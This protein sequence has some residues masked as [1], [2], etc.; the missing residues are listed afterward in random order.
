MAQPLDFTKFPAGEIL[1]PTLGE[2]V[3]VKGFRRDAPTKIDFAAVECV[4]RNVC[5][6]S[7]TKCA[8]CALNRFVCPECCAMYETVWRAVENPARG[9]W[10]RDAPKRKTK[11]EKDAAMK[12][13]PLQTDVERLESETA[14]GDDLSAE[15]RREAWENKIR[16]LAAAEDECEQMERLA[17]EIAKSLKKRREKLAAKRREHT[18]NGSREYDE[19]DE[20]PLLTLAE[21]I[22]AQEAAALETGANV[23][24]T[25]EAMNRAA[26]Q[27]FQKIDLS[28]WEDAPVAALENAL[29]PVI[30]AA[31]SER[32][33]TLGELS[34]WLD[35]SNRAKIGLAPKKIEAIQEAFRRLFEPLERAEEEKAERLAREREER[36]DETSAS[37]RL[38][39]DEYKEIAETFKAALTVDPATAP[40]EVDRVWFADA[41]R[42]AFKEPGSFT[43][44]DLKRTRVVAG[45]VAARRDAIGAEIDEAIR[46]VE[47]AILAGSPPEPIA[48]GVFAEIATRWKSSRALD[49]DDATTLRRYFKAA[50]TEAERRVA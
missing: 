3:V 14:P 19:R 5:A 16:E 23:A 7:E 27:P 8:D 36:R 31:L 26:T 37:E 43:R 9:I 40:P 44:E 12:C 28:N 2:R 47:A 35:D 15:R 18:R 30:Y 50:S 10:R 34:A 1:A 11:R 24:A 6:T 41:S 17:R 4:R 25:L 42:R 32:F 39:R 20:T 48:P 46:T 22:S 49:R 29:S 33:Q 21:Q 13:E 45:W 38:T